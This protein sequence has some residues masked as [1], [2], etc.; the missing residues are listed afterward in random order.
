MGKRSD[1]VE[2]TGDGDLRVESPDTR[3]RLR[4]QQGRYWVV[5]D[6]VGLVILRKVLPGEEQDDAS[7]GDEFDDMFDA[8]IGLES[9]DI[10]G[11]VRVILAGEVLTS[12]T[13]FQIIE[14]I[15]NRNW[16]GDLRVFS[17]RGSVF[18]LKFEQGALR[19]AR[20]NEEEGLLG[21]T[22]IKEGV[23]SP[24]D[25]QDVLEHV[26][27]EKRLGDLLVEL[28]VLTSE[29]LFDYLGKQIKGVFFRA[30]LVPDGTYVFTTPDPKA[31]PP[32]HTVLLPVRALLMEGIQRVDEMEL[33]RDVIPAMDVTFKRRND[34]TEG[35]GPD[36]LALLPYCDEKHTLAE[37]ATLTGLGEFLATKAAYHLVK[38]K[39]VDVVMPTRVDTETVERYVDGLNEILKTVFSTI[40][41]HGDSQVARSNLSAWVSGSGYSDFFGEELA[42][43]GAFDRQRLV[44]TIKSS[45][46]EDPLESLHQ[47]GHEFVSFA[48]FSAGSVLPRDAEREL[49]ATVNTR[50]QQLRAR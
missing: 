39:R 44:D 48:L 5:T 17:N 49:S 9:S 46:D 27:K 3:F 13:L 6:A 31:E 43:D 15:S 38:R 29:Q 30:L 41:A 34:R 8:A 2:I 21:Q 24:K 28:E 7:G 45:R 18:E 35:L 14:T 47:I 37:I 19:H 22:L 25:L 20:S 32:A 4:G 12:M 11:N 33:Y 42:P 16:D 36:S 26:S 40:S 50:L 10:E 1:Q 23:L